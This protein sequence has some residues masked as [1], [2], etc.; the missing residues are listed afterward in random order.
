MHH[1]LSIPFMLLSHNFLLNL[2]GVFHYFYCWFSGKEFSGK[3][4][5]SASTWFQPL[6]QDNL[7]EREMA[8]HFS[9]LAPPTD[10]GTWWATVRGV[11]KELDR[12]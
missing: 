6:G 11:A 1:S 7:L 3:S 2:F 10:R 8:T 5:A 12:N 4:T 9:T